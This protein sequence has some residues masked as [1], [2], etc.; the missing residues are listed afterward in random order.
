MSERILNNEIIR[1]IAIEYN[2]PLYIYDRRVIK[3]NY[4]CLKDSLYPGASLYYAMK[5]N[6]LLG[7]CEILA[8]EGAGIEVASTGEMKVALKSGIDGNKI[9]FTSPGKTESEIDYA[10]KNNIKIINIDSLDEAE[11]VNKIAKSSNKNVNIGLRINPSVSF[12][13]AKIKM[14]GIAILTEFAVSICR[15]S[16]ETAIA[17]KIDLGGK[18]IIVSISIPIITAL[19]EIIL[20]I[21]P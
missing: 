9:I 17:S 21:L 16:G 11:I 2:T 15:D 10:I 5:C 13:N 12:S 18:I 3:N 6:P 8:N 1:K 14:T 4:R 19:L 20:Q 7:I